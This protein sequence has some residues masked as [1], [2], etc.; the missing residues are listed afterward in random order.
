MQNSGGRKKI[1]LGMN[2][3]RYFKKI[4]FAKNI[5]NNVSHKA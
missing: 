3:S 5:K 1:I 2:F 4:G